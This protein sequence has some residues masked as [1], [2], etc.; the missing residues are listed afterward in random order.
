[1]HLRWS[2]PVRPNGE[3]T[4]Y[5]VKY[6]PQVEK[7]EKE[8]KEEEREEEDSVV[9]RV[10]EAATHLEITELKP[11]VHYDFKVRNCSDIIS[12][13]FMHACV[14]HSLIPPL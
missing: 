11:D 7:K 8:E 12:D 10:D 13:I 5:E 9:V 14:L 4:G 2:A 3:I 1:M 6:W